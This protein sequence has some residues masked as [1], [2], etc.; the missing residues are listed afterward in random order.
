MLYKE[1][2]KINLVWDDF[3][4]MKILLLW[5]NLLDVLDS[6]G[7]IELLG[8]ILLSCLV[9]LLNLGLVV[10]YAKYV[11]IPQVYVYYIEQGLFLWKDR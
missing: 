2:G 7:C 10:F 8:E 6:I 5:K 1:G 3:N 9:N 4:I 11:E